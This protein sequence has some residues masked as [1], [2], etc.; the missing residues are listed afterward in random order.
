MA[1]RKIALLTDSTCDLTDEELNEHDIRMLSM[2]IVYEGREYR[3]RRDISLQQVLNRLGEEVPHSSLPLPEDV[4]DCLDGIV[5]A[6]YT[7][8]LYICVSSQLSGTYQMVRMLGAQYPD[9]RFHGLDSRAMSMGVGFLV[10]E[11]AKALAE[12]HDIE[13]VIKRLEGIRD[14]TR[15]FFVMP[16]LKY[17]RLGGRIGAV[18]A[19]LGSTL[20]LKPVI[21][22][23]EGRYITAA[24]VRGFQNAVTRM[25]QLVAKHFGQRPV[26]LAVAHADAPEE[27]KTLCDRLH[28]AL[29]VVQSHLRQISPVLG[30]HSG[31]GLLGLVAYPA[32]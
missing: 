7:D 21:T 4:I 1:E 25:E 18:A 28:E 30:V 2:R 32:I 3:D 23:S 29:N 27:A 13:K 20:N 10:L 5:E 11:A 6:G 16:T 15:T 31:P 17:L 8:V 9:L 19:V 24:K 12:T 22:I 14:Q 26:H